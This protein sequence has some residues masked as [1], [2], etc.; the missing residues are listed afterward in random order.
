VTFKNLSEKN[1]MDFSRYNFEGWEIL[2][3]HPCNYLDL[4]LMLIGWPPL[5]KAR[6]V[7]F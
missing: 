1:V 3:I 7:F 4:M 6:N 5:H 2:T